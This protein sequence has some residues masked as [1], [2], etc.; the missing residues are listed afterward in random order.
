MQ[1]MCGHLVP[2]IKTQNAYDFRR[3]PRAGSSY[4]R[5]LCGLK[6]ISAFLTARF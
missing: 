3:T 6:L 5:V 4:R 2:E 1:N